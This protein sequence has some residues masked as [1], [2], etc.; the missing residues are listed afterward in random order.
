[1]PGANDN[2]SGVAVL[3]ALA[4]ALRERP[5][6]GLRVLLVSCGSEEVLQGGIH[7]F[8]ERHFPAL[9]PESTWVVN[10]DSVGSPHLA[11]IEGEGPFVMEDFEPA[12]K[13]LV[14]ETAEQSGIELRRGLRARLSTD[15]VIPHR[16]GYPVANFVSVNA[17]KA[18]SNYHWPTDVPENVD[19]STVADAAELTLRIAER[20]GGG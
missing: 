11:L 19:Y 9:P 6:E 2:L 18:V 16:G 20:L 12:F 5:V 8:A 14:E 13:D 17:W 3:V 7:G 4:E 15:A 1:M 10:H